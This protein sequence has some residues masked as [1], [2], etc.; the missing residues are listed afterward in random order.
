M[1]RKPKPAAKPAMPKG[2]TTTSN[3]KAWRWKPEPYRLRPDGWQSVTFKSPDG[4]Y[5]TL[6]QAIDAAAEI[7]ALVDDWYE[8]GLSPVGRWA[9][10]APADTRPKVALSA[11]PDAIGKLI[12][13]WLGVKDPVTKKW[14]GG[15]VKF[16]ELKPRTQADYRN[17]MHRFVETLAGH[18]APPHR[19]KLPIG[20]LE[21]EI[22]LY[23]ADMEATRNSSVKIL[24]ARDDEETPPLQQVYYDQ[25]FSGAELG[26]AMT[27]NAKAVITTAHIWLEWVVKKKRVLPYNPASAVECK[28]PPGRVVIWYEDERQAMLK[29]ADIMGWKSI[30]FGAR[31]SRELSW[32]RGD[33][34]ALKLG[35][36]REDI[37]YVKGQPP[38]RVV[39][40]EGSRLKTDN[41]TFTTLTQEGIALYDEII[42]WHK[43][44]LPGVTLLPSQPMLVVDAVAGRNDQGAVGKAWSEDYFTHIF[45]E[46][47]NFAAGILGRPV[48]K[49]FADLRDSAITE[50]NEAGLTRHHK[51]SRSQHSL[52]SIDQMD[53]KHYGLTTT[54]ISDEAAELLDAYRALKAESQGEVDPERTQKELK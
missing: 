35:Q 17:R 20:V 49:R 7:N 15:T 42:A 5:M 28:T 6:G 2:L 1:T 45:R 16:N 14:T 25:I 44:R 22:R 51:Q 52:E 37:K 21:H 11:K 50:M 24:L 46:V 40:V 8:R 34:V 10:A 43:A 27:H 12:D 23:D 19:K 26:E 38:R 54:A 31:L 41:R 33:I 39:R 9:I 18:A 48:D 3:G 4:S 53:Q 13:E 29:A 47:C 36:F 30:A 32:S